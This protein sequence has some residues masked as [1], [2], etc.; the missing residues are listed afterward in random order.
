MPKVFI[1]TFG[2][3]T[4]PDIDLE[5]GTIQENHI[6]A[7]LGNPP[8]IPSGTELH[9]SNI[10]NVFFIEDKTGT[11]TEDALA[12]FYEGIFRNKYYELLNKFD[13]NNCFY[14]KEVSSYTPVKLF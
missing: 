10:H 3:S 6:L 9:M 12:K 5:G 4:P 2:G 13:W 11:L 1:V 14:V 8:M 7:I